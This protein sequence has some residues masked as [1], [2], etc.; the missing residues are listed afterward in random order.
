MQT[1]SF[2]VTILGCGTSTGVPMIFCKC[3]VCRSKN[4]K[5]QRLRASIW[6][7]IQNKSFLIDTSPDLRQQAMR[8]KINRIDAV[9]YTHPHADHIGGIDEIRS[10]NFHQKERIPVWG[11]DWTIQDIR[12][13]YPYLF[14]ETLATIGGGI[15]QVILNEFSLDDPN[16]IA[17]GVPIIPIALQHGNNQVAGFRMGDFAYLT[18]CNHIPDSS[19]A[20]L[21]GLDTVVLDCLKLAEHDTHMNFKQSLLMAKRIDA[22]RTYLTHMSH[23]FDYIKTSRLLPKNIYLAYDGLT[24]SG[25]PHHD[26]RRTKRNKK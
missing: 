6:V 11:H 1:G 21:Q 18:D 14:D 13:R 8:A 16:F 22:Q 9:L 24:I 2:Q 12:T 10:F 7:R 20:R 23:D 3:A 5:N 17:A 19:L 25:G 26:R 4:P 15:A